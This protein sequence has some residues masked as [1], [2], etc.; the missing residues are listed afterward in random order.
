MLRGFNFKNK[1]LGKASHFLKRK[2]TMHL[3][4]ILKY[5]VFEQIYI[6]C[7]Q[8]HHWTPQLLSNI[9]VCGIP[10]LSMG[11]KSTLIQI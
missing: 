9:C 7:H 1:C 6:T 10:M 3:L 4:N 8:K 5:K 2:L 11:F